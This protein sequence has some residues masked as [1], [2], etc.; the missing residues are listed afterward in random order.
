MHTLLGTGFYGY[1]GPCK[2][3]FLLKKGDIL[4]DGYIH[5]VKDRF[6]RNKAVISMTAF[7]CF[8]TLNTSVL[9]SLDIT[10]SM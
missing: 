8:I 1:K 10:C 2:W 6:M 3:P 5:M 9:Y 7:Y 4:K